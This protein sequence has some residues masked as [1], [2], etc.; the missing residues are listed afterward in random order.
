MTCI[1]TEIVLLVTYV[2][3][4]N[5]PSGVVGACRLDLAY[6]HFKVIPA[7]TVCKI[8]MRVASFHIGLITHLALSSHGFS[9]ILV[10]YEAM[11]RN[12]APL[13]CFG[14]CQIIDLS[15]L[16]LLFILFFVSNF[17]GALRSSWINE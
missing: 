8:D 15:I 13:L 14:L 4:L 5:I 12:R 6:E 1:L 9:F 17:C 2:K 16:I 10:C 3:R 7:C 11:G